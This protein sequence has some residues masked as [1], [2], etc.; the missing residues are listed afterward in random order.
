MLDTNKLNA[1]DLI[2]VGVYTAL[3]FVVLFAV[4]MTGLIPVMMVVL[5]FLTAFVVA[6]PF[7]LYMTK[8]KKFG[9]LTITGIIFGLLFTLTG[10][11]WWTIIAGFA[12]GFIGDLLVKSGDYKSKNKG[13]LAYICVTVVQ[14]SAYAPLFFDRENQFKALREGYGD[15]YA[16]TLASLTPHW[17]FYVAVVTMILGGYFGSLFGI[18]I[19]KK[20]FE[21]A[22]IV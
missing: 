2:N 15:A 8:V 7:M 11:Y 4:G 12:G 17:V 14:L 18:K 19:L 21:K 16:D 5:P 20:H 10:H 9:M 13:I 22:G 6:I 1:K 3:C